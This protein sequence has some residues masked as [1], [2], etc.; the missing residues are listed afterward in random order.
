MDVPGPDSNTGFGALY[1]G[2][3]P[4]IS[5]IQPVPV[6][7]V[8]APPPQP[9]NVAIV[10]P[11]AV[12]PPTATPAL[13]KKPQSEN[14]K[15]LFVIPLFFFG[16]V[17]LPGI[18]GLGGFALI[19]AVLYNRRAKREVQAP[20]QDRRYWDVPDG[21]VF[22]PPQQAMYPVE[23]PLIPIIC[24]NCGKENKPGMNFCT[25]CGTDLSARDEPA[26][27]KKRFCAK[28]GNPLSSNA[29]FCPKCGE[30]VK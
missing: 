12:G 5:Q 23:Q 7:S 14:D 16:C 9:T 18:I 3:P 17:V 15:N 8:E 21:E 19:G 10:I 22:I 20:E 24:P 25:S 30:Q 28:C 4:N 1:L 2:D 27:D 11:T 6:P 13:E 26:K 29:K